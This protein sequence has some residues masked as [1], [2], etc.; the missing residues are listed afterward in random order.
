MTIN[1]V[2]VLSAGLEM[3][4][5]GKE[6]IVA[7]YLK[8]HSDYAFDLHTKN[9]IEHFE[10]AAKHLGFTLTPIKAEAEAETCAA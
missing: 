9:A 4:S 5:G 8:P 1:P 7:F 10:K 3:S 2:D 6:A